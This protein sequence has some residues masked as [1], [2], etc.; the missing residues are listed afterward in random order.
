MP[1][2]CTS[3]HTDLHILSWISTWRSDWSEIRSYKYIVPIVHSHLS[4]PPYEI[5]TLHQ[6]KLP[7]VETIRVLLASVAIAPLPD[8]MNILIRA[9]LIAASPSY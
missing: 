4:N 6:G 9:I 7:I 8:F 2:Q 5:A 1:I 3:F